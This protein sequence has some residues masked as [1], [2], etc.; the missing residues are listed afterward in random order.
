MRV[1]LLERAVTYQKHYDWPDWLP[2]AQKLYAEGHSSVAVGRQV[3]HAGSTVITWL[4]RSGVTI[5]RQG[6]TV[7]AI[8]R[9]VVHL[10]I[11]DPE[12]ARY[13]GPDC[14]IFTRCC[15][16]NWRALIAQDLVTARVDLVN[17]AG[18]AA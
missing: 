11:T 9:P 12:N 3:G 10:M 5:R 17:C 1:W 8:R 18:R 15:G 2:L 4:R 14:E 13:D 6:A 7:I 16:L